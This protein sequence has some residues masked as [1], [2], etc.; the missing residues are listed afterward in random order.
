[1]TGDPMTETA[2]VVLV[3][4]ASAGIGL[5]CA[6][7]LHRAGWTVV[8]ASRRGTTVSDRTPATG[9]GHAPGS[10]TSDRTPATGDGHAPGTATSD[11][12]PA[13]GDGHAPGTAT[14]DSAP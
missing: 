5:A 2:K 4:G 14:S 13:T 8:G 7:R 6:D 10:A 11:R 1:M 9:D 12:T 3:T